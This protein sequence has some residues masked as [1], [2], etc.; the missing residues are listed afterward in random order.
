M[1]WSVSDGGAPPKSRGV[2]LTIML[3]LEALGVVSGLVALVVPGL[4]ESRLA[5]LPPWY[6]AYFVGALLIQA[7][8][9]VGIWFWK[10]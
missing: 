3:A 2:F 9:V 6:A 7:V 10:R 4:L 5:G 8:S 1:S